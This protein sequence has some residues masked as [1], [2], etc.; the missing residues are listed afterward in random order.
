ML[1]TLYFQP[2]CSAS[3]LACW[4]ERV[5]ACSP[6]FFFFLTLKAGS[7]LKLVHAAYL[8]MYSLRLLTGEMSSKFVER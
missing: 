6:V 3:M 4:W 8:L 7:L 5:P 1:T 2:S